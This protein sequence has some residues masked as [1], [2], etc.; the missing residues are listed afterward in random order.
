MS[1]NNCH[2]SRVGGLLYRLRG[3]RSL[4]GVVGVACAGLLAVSACSSGGSSGGSSGA[5]A[6]GSASGGADVSYF[7]G[8]TITLVAPDNPGG[9]FDEYSRIIAPLMG[10]YLGATVNVENVPAGNTVVGQNTVAHAQPNGLTIGWLNSIEDVSFSIGAGSGGVNFDPNDEAMIGAPGQSIQVWVSDPSSSYKTWQSIVNST[11]TVNTLDVTS[12][13]ADL[14]LRALYGAYGVKSKIVTGYESPKLL[15]AG[16]LRHDAPVAE[17]EFTV[18]ADA[19]S[20]GQ[21]HPVLTSN[22]PPAGTKGLDGVPTIAQIAKQ[23]PPKTAAGQAALQEVV[24]LTN[25][26][27]IL[28]APQGTPAGEQAALQAA[29]KSA[30]S[31]ASAV[32]QEVTEGLTPGFFSG[33]QTETQYKGALAHANLLKPYISPSSS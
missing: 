5:A 9:S 13:T 29:A 27:A 32:K 19:I 23:F 1:F 22:A 33:Q 4:L 30:L 28:F 12:G 3:R 7:H 10:K 14:Y 20:S 24:S 21:A 16:F 18:F 26:G 2:R 31:D 17:E 8:K 15:A 6:S 25:L 11:Q